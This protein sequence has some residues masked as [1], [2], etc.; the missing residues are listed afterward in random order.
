MPFDVV[1]VRR[2]GQPEP[3][4]LSRQT[5]GV[6]VRIGNANVMLPRGPPRLRDH[7]PHRAPG[8]LLRRRTTSS[9]GTSTATAGPSPWTRF[10]PTSACR[11]AVPAGAAQGR[12][13]HRAVR[14][15]RARLRSGGARR[16]RELPHH[17]QAGRGRG[18]DHRVH[19]PEGHRRAAVL[20]EQGRPLA[21]GQPRRGGGRRRLPRARS[22]SSTGAGR[23]SGATR[24]PGPPFPRYEAPTGLG[25][26]GAR[27][28]DNMECDDRCFASALLGLGQRGYLSIR[29][30]GGYVRA[31]AH[32]QGRR[33]GCRARRRSRRSRRRRRARAPSADLRPGGAAGARRSW[34]R[35]SSSISARSCSRA[36]AVTGVGMV[37]ARGDPGRDV[38]PRRARRRR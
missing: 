21:E 11:T 35:R 1:S 2:D 8:R 36:T 10:P 18:P 9:T 23:R 15:A 13:L 26:A 17:A 38:R 28:L 4:S 3:Y 19:V 22:P 5:N 14:R 7:L 30:E 24:A 33:R 12:G 31:R 34:T 27:Y 20:R 37:L 25:P 16:R 6:S 29:E 32:R